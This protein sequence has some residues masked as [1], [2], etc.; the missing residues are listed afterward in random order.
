MTQKQT[1]ILGLVTL[2]A[3]L[4]AVWLVLGEAPSGPNAELRGRALFP[5]LADRLDR[6][7]EVHIAGAGSAV[8]LSR[9]DEGWRIE[10]KSGYRAAPAQVR[11]L[12]IA[13][14]E[15]EIRQVKTDNPALYDRIGL[16]EEATTLELR[17]EAG[18]GVLSLDVGQRQYRREDFLTFVRPREEQTTYLVD[19]LPELRAEP[20]EWLSDTILE[21]ERPRIASVTIERPDAPTMEV[22]RAAPED[23]FVLADIGEDEQYIG[24]RPAGQLATAAST[25][26]IDDVRPAGEIDLGAAEE[27]VR[28]ATFDG[29]TVTMRLFDTGDETGDA[30]VTLEASYTPP[31]ETEGPEQM[32]EA[33]ADGVQEAEEIQTRS[34]GWL[35]RI[36]SSKVGAITRSR[37]ELVEP[38]PAED[39]VEDGEDTGEPDGA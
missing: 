19:S 26:R 24:F 13:L 34:E 9:S 15:S 22:S 33:P 10:Q 17:D 11:E 3:V 12:F 37:E 21:V 18:E 16:G 8:T 38:K 20:S 29:L 23:E 1:T 35:F 32:P 27:T 14:L 6:V 39:E 25:L 5:N 31:S 28:L 2:V 30:W 4:A 7:H 36:P